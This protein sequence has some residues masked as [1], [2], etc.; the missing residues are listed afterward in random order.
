MSQVHP[1]PLSFTAADV[2]AG[3]VRTASTTTPLTGLTGSL[4][5]NLDLELEII[6]I[7]LLGGLLSGLLDT[8]AALIAP[9]IGAL[10]QVLVAVLEILGIGIGQVDVA[11]HGFDCRNAALVQ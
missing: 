5:S 6:G 10:D 4:L 9:A 11:V 8:V 3:T 2:A 7:N 1:V